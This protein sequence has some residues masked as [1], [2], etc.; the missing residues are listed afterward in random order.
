MKRTQ[1]NFKTV[2]MTKDKSHIYSAINLFELHCRRLIKN[3]QAKK[4]LAKNFCHISV[5]LHRILFNFFVLVVNLNFYCSSE[6]LEVRANRLYCMRLTSLN[7]GH[8]GF[9][10]R[11]SRINSDRS[12]PTRIVS[13]CWKTSSKPEQVFKL[14]LRDRLMKVLS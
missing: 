13:F 5:N 4:Y 14:K 6:A 8:C 1:V 9:R 10:A 2:C 11:W 12:I 3:C 7:Y